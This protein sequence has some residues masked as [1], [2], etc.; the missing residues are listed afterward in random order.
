M[1]SGRKQLT[2][3]GLLLL[4]A[5]V[6]IAGC[7]GGGSSSGPLTKAEYVAQANKICVK[8]NK[9]VEEEIENYAGEH[10]LRYR[11]PSKK[12]FEREAE[13]VFAPSVERKIDQLQE[14][15]PPANDEQTV[16][17]MLSAAEKGLQEGKSDFTT[18][19]SGQALGEARKLAT[20]YGLKECF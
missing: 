8:E 4:L 15:E 9:R 16:D 6:V 1:F 5:A 20:E 17:K 19:I 10:N 3:I 13:D 11:T 18:L 12:D 2:G 7:G 14:L